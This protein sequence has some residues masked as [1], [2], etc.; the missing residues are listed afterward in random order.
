MKRLTQGK[1]RVT[2]LKI[3]ISK[4]YDRFEWGFIGNMLQKFG[5]SET[6]RDRIMRLVTSVSY[7]FIHNGSVFGDVVPQRRVR[8]GDPISPNIYILCVEGLSSIIRRNEDVGFLHGC[9]IA[10]GAHAI[11]YL[12]FADDCYFFF[13][14]NKGIRW[15]SWDR[16]CSVKGDDGLGFKKLRNFNLAMLAKQAWRLINNANSLV[17]SL[18]R[19]RYFP[20][21]DFVNAW[22]GANPSYV[23]RS[24]F[25]TQDVV[26]QG[27]RHRIGDGQSTKI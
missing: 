13:R 18:M 25:E 16:L 7:N 3:D 12:L 22:I 21:S 19:A 20:N 8:K 23:W 9:V 17:T 1:H 5:F 6:W 10:R 24:I 15:M 2:G 14:A 4:T 11:S 27:C 26:R